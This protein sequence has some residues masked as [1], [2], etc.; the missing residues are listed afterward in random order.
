MIGQ[1]PDIVSEAASSDR[2]PFGKLMRQP[3]LH[4]LAAFVTFYVGVEVT[5]GGMCRD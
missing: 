1:E 4:F 2:N 5:I 3:A